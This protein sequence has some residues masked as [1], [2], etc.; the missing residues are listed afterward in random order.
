MYWSWQDSGDLLTLLIVASAL[1]LAGL[2]ALFLRQRRVRRSDA[3]GPAWTRQDRLAVA[4][5]ASGIVLGVLGSVLP[6]VASKDSTDPSV[7]DTG[8][9]ELVDTSVLNQT[10]R[11]PGPAIDLKLR[12]TGPDVSLLTDL[13]LTIE[14]ADDL[15][16]C[17]PGGY[18]E[19]SYVYD[20]RLPLDPEIGEKVTTSISQ[21]VRPN[22]TDRF[23][24]RISLEVFD[25]A[26]IAMNGLPIGF[27]TYIAKVDIQHD[28]GESLDGGRVVLLVPVKREYGPT[29]AYANYLPL[30]GDSFSQTDPCY[31][32]NQEV[33]DEL[34]GAEAAAL[35]PGFVATPSG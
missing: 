3:R 19:T 9:L 22:H 1:L 11:E 7:N 17:E 27:K 30:P 33:V 29:A 31:L 16:I 8:R 12:N 23:L 2:V 15:V 13:T 25:E 14:Y 18:Q 32:H 6:I 34:V 35:P 21:E 4:S 28:G 26:P 20:V 10:A 24:A 5:L